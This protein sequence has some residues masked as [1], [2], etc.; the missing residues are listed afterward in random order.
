[1]KMNRRAALTAIA[2][3]LTVVVAV[4]AY[5]MLSKESKTASQV[6]PNPQVS[7][8]TVPRTSPPDGRLSIA[9]PAEPATDGEAEVLGDVQ[10]PVVRFSP[11]LREPTAFRLPAFVLPEA[12]GFFL[13]PGFILTGP[14]QPAPPPTTSPTP[15]DPPAP[16]P[17]ITEPPT[18]PPVTEPP[19]TSPPVTDPP[20]TSPPVTDPPVTDPPPTDTLPP[21]TLPPDTTPIP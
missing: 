3:W 13:P 7:R 4:F 16:P 1:M 14:S 19:T 18:T 12:S 9:V 5:G 15:T 17:T 11:F 10:L 20:T 2:A 6:G 21:D 8:S